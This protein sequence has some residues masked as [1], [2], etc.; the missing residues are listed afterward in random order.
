[1]AL[2]LCVGSCVGHLPKVA[3]LDLCEAASLA[4]PST[5]VETEHHK[6]AVVC[7]SL[8]AADSER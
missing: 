1:M 6:V 4:G 5:Q 2:R 3:P 7:H 8:Q